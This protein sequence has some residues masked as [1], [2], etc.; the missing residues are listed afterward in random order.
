MGKVV[1]LSSFESNRQSG[2]RAA[3]TSE[4]ARIIMFTGVRYERIIQKEE[5]RI[6]PIG[7]I[8]SRLGLGNGRKS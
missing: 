4:S 7:Q 1:A 8:R 5:A 6:G 2:K 3:T